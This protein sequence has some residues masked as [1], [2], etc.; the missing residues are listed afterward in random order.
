MINTKLYDNSRERINYLVAKCI[1]QAC[2]NTDNLREVFRG[3]MRKFKNVNNISD[4][5]PIQ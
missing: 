4:S 3:D 1:K 2:V 5:T